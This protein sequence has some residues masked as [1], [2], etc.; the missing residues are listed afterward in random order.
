[1][2]LEMTFIAGGLTVCDRVPEKRM[3]RDARFIPPASLNG[4]SI[5]AMA[6]AALLFPLRPIFF[7]PS[8]ELNLSGRVLKAA[9]LDLEGPI[10]GGCDDCE[11]RRS[12]SFSISMPNAKSSG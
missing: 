8:P 6:S 12:A 1:L 5:V 10:E 7:D 9:P 11:C 2:L 3:N 4:G